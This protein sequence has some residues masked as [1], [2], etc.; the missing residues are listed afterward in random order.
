MEIILDHELTN[1]IVSH[2]IGSPE[3]GIA[4]VHTGLEQVI[5]SPEASEY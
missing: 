1:T 2:E 3:V 5:D 4:T